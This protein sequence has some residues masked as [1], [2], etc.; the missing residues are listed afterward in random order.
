VE[1]FLDEARLVAD[2][3]HENIVQIYQLARQD[4]EFFMVLEYVHGMSLRDFIRMHRILERQ[5]PGELAVFIVS[6]IA[7]GLAYAHSRVAPDGHPLNIV[8]RDVCP[9]NILI[10]TE[11][12]PKLTDFGVARAAPSACAERIRGLVGKLRYISPEQAA[13][14]KV[15]FRSDIYSLGL[16]LFELLTLHKAIPGTTR[17]EVLAAAREGRVAWDLLPEDLS[18]DLLRILRRMLAPVPDERYDSTD[19]LGYELEY[20]IYHKGYGPTVVTLEN[21]LRE[22][23]PGLYRECA[24]PVK[25][26]FVEQRTEKTVVLP[27]PDSG[28]PQ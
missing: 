4:N 13:C 14:R 19:R 2:L 11:G 25:R 12:L 21:Y 8:H 23:A 27:S 22:L 18:E 10:T 20:H 3:V 7:R 16:V 5:P 26:P 17:D 6:R 24:V 15:D 1:L 28:I 9:N